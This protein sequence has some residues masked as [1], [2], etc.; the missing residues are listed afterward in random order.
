M[1]KIFS[2]VEHTSLLWRKVDA[3]YQKGKKESLANG[4]S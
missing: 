2:L 3:F 4:P 1:N